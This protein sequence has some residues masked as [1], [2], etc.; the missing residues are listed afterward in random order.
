MGK[1]HTTY[2]ERLDRDLWMKTLIYDLGDWPLHPECVK[3]LVD[4]DSA[5]WMRFKVMVIKLTEICTGDM[6]SKL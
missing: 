6:I 2:I 4:S 3:L 5:R 1:L